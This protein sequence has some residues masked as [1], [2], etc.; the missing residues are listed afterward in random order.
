MHTITLI[1]EKKKIDFNVHILKHQ[2]NFFNVFIDDIVKEKTF[3]L[4]TVLYSEKQNKF[5]IKKIQ[6]I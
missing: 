4:E 6:K 3:S 5:M 2:Q 1:C